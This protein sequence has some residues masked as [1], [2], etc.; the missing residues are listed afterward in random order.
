MWDA[1]LGAAGEALARLRV[2]LVERLGLRSGRRYA[3]VA[4]GADARPRSAL[5]YDSAWHG[6]EGGLA[7]ALAAAARRRPAPR[8]RPPSGPTATT[9][10]STIGGLPARTHASQGE[11][12]SLALA[13]RLAAHQLVTETVGMPPVLLLD[14]VFSELDPGRCDALLDDLPPGQT[15][16]TTAGGLP[17][18]AQPEQVLHVTADR[19]ARGRRALVGRAGAAARGPAV[20]GGSWRPADPV[21]QRGAA[22][23]AGDPAAI[24]APLDRLL[25]RAG[26]PAGR[27]PRCPA[28]S[29]GTSSS[30]RPSPTTVGP[31]RSTTACWSSGSPSRRWA[32][33]WRYRQGEVLRR[34]DE[35]LGAGVVARIDVRGAPVLRPAGTGPADGPSRHTRRVDSSKACSPCSTT[36][37]TEEHRRSQ[38]AEHP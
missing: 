34:L 37:L 15:L 13:L 30:A 8:R 12:R 33:E 5:A 9:S 20:S 23:R 11:Q 28:S 14:D 31:P 22:P 6:R 29:A 26:R 19:P 27:C 32:T 18:G 1:K 4:V 10:T 17:P 3:A 7:D 38:A 35:H 21:D 25:D 16:L 2:A 24:G 36:R